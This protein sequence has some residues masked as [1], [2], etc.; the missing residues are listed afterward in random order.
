MGVLDAYASEAAPSQAEEQRVLQFDIAY[1]S[2]ASDFLIIL[3]LTLYA[4]LILAPV[5]LIT[6]DLISASVIAMLLLALAFG[7]YVFRGNVSRKTG[8][9]TILGPELNIEGKKIKPFRVKSRGVKQVDE[10]TL[11]FLTSVLFDNR[12]HF[13]TAE[14]CAK[15][16]QKIRAL[17]Y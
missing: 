11:R 10:K 14:Q 5:F 4:P 7:I 6:F 15:A 17:G 9:L 3:I 8:T 13:D 1:S 2:T 12:I 16:V